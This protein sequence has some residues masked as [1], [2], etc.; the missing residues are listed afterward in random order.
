MLSA[1]RFLGLL[2]VI[3]VG[4]IGFGY[5]A[6][7]GKALKEY[8]GTIVK[9]SD[10]DTVHVQVSARER[11]KVR[12]ESIDTP[13]LHL[14]TKKGQ[15]NQGIHAIRADEY[16]RSLIPLGTRVTLQSFGADNYG[17]VLGRIIYKGQDINL[18]MVESGWAAPYIIC[19]GEDCDRSYMERH[20]VADYL[21]A[22]EE[23][24]DAGR[25]IY[26]PE[27][28]LEELPFEFRLSAQGRKP[29]KF[30]GDFKTRSLVEPAQY[31]QVDHCRRI[32]FMDP[33][34]ALDIGFQFD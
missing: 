25:G 20:D 9:I 27:N 28:P 13:E 22:C 32:F 5:E 26:N 19:D 12:M 15:V 24:R 21:R 14:Q 3:H 1:L 18:R 6:E 16:L 33:A 34:E 23:A 30:V 29:D 31:R 8:Q 11:F 7:A 4:A 10:G 17:R 2:A